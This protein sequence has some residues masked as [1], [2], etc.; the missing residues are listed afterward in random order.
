MVKLK[1]LVVTMA[2]ATAFFGLAIFGAE[3]AYAGACDK[4]SETTKITVMGDWLAWAVQAPVISAMRNGYYKDE[5]LDVELIQP[6]Q[7]ADPIRLVAAEKVQFSMT[8]VPEIF[9]ARETAIPVVAIAVTLRPLPTALMVLPDSGIK[10]PADLKGKT[11][12]VNVVPSAMSGLRTM[13]ATAGLTIDDVDI[14]DPGYGVVPL[15]LSGKVDAGYALTYFEGVLANEELA[16][17]GKPP[18]EFLMYRDYGVPNYYYQLLAANEDWLKINAATTCRFLRATT[19]GF[20]TFKKNPEPMIKWMADEN[21]ALTPEQH[22]KIVE[23]TMADWTDEDGNLWVQD[24]KMWAETQDWLVEEG[25]ISVP[26]DPESYFT[27]DYLP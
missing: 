19:R 8:Y 20:E 2:V 13:L 27:N 15:Q 6:A 18:V 16:K 11:L 17:E 24:V 14:I 3:R 7:A 9:Q 23:L 4:S 1:S 10:S 22:R 25:L 21:E 5:G 12:G 26:A